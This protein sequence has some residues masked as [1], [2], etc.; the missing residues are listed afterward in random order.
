MK[1]MKCLLML[2]MPFFLIGCHT[3]NTEGPQYYQRNSQKVGYVETENIQWDSATEETQE[4]SD[5][6]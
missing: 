3:F 5:E 1:T 2:T 6:I 4:L